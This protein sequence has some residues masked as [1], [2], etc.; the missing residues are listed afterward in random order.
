MAPILYPDWREKVVFS[1][2]GVQPQTLAE[3]DGFKV[4]VAG[5]EPGQKIPLHPE[6][7]AMYHFLEGTG[8]INVEDER[9][10]VK[11]GTIMIIP[12][13]ARRG[14]DAETRLTFLGVR[15]A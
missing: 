12:A 2:E 1:D 7:R 3:M 5:L 15:M 14:V 6:G 10:P 4:L 8:W 11:P 13:G 9:F